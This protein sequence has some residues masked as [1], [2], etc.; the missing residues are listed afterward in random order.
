MRPED[1]TICGLCGEELD[2][3]SFKI[4]EW[5]E[6]GYLHSVYYC[7]NVDW[8]IPGGTCWEQRVVEDFP[9]FEEWLYYGFE[10]DGCEPDEWGECT[11]TSDGWKSV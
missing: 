1:T 2:W 3:N 11:C 8:V 7:H 6:D 10:C 5:E 4:E 9:E